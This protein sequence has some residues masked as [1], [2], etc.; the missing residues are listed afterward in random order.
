MDVCFEKLLDFQPS[1]LHASGIALWQ[2]VPTSGT[3]GKPPAAGDLH[4]PSF[5]QG[6]QKQ[7]VRRQ[8]EGEPGDVLRQLLSPALPWRGSA[9]QLCMPHA[10]TAKAILPRCHMQGSGCGPPQ[11]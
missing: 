8:H 5:V 1:N 2:G 10:S 9:C 6:V 11:H 4:T 3:L 7:K